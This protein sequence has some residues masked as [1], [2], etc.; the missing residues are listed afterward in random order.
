MKSFTTASF[1]K[2]YA[3]LSPE[4]KLQA[5]K[6]YRLWQENSQHPSLRFKKV[7]KQLWSV[8]LS[9]NFRAVAFKKGDDYY[10]TWIG[11]HA[12]YDQFLDK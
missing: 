5:Q 10:W 8:R 6:A 11:S 2:A 12:E 1:W 3:E 4:M 7:G 9:D